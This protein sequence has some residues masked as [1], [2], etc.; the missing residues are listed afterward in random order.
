MRKND[1]RFREDLLSPEEEMILA[2]E[3]KLACSSLICRIQVSTRHQRLIELIRVK[4]DTMPESFLLD[5]AEYRKLVDFASPRLGI[6]KK[7]KGTRR[8]LHN[9]VEDQGETVDKSG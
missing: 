2:S 1:K 7:K 8:S 3:R 9:A 5:D 6:P 4:P